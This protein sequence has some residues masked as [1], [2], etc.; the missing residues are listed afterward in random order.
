MVHDVPLINSY[1]EYT[2]DPTP[3]I[4]EPD[5]PSLLALSGTPNFDTPSLREPPSN[6][7]IELLGCE[8][9]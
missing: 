4:A 6:P 8:Y 1:R 2:S 3:R 5:T 7:T 9:D